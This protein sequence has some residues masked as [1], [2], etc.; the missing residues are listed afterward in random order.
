MTDTF[1]SSSLAAI[2]FSWAR[3][4][5]YSALEKSGAGALEQETQVGMLT[6]VVCLRRGK[7][8]TKPGL[9]PEVAIETLAD[10]HA[11]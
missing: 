4:S 8:S 10:L 7:Q 1:L 2:L 9:Q 3:V 5:G 11:G 6:N